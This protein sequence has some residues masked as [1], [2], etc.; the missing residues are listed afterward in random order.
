MRIALLTLDSLVNAPAVR[1]FLVSHANEVVLVGLSNPYRPNAGGM[2]GQ[3]VRHVRRSGLWILPYLIA[4]FSFSEAISLLSL[5]RIFPRLFYQSLPRLCLGLGV[6]TVVVDDVNSSVFARQIRDSGADLIITFHF[7]QILSAETIAI[8]E[9]G[10]LNVHPSLLPFHRGPL[11]TFYALLES[12][13]RMGVSVHRLVPRIDAGA[14]LAQEAVELPEGI[15][16]TAASFFLHQRGRV[17]LEHVLAS[18]NF[19]GGKDM[20]PCP[21]LSFPLRQELAAGRTRGICLVRMKDLRLLVQ[22][23]PPLVKHTRPKNLP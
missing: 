5:D 23:A 1:D 2:F 9:H 8:C 3:V 6:R 21:Y 19:D 13:P 10:G 11:P 14:V 17:L 18:G 16:A 15:S 4:N 20:D 12:P 22:K 7:D